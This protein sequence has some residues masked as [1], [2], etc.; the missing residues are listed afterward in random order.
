MPAMGAGGPM[1]PG[2][3]GGMGGGGGMA[4]AMLGGS[5]KPKTLK[6]RRKKIGSLVVALAVKAFHAS[7][8]K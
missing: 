7:M 4:A 1:P 6:L 5:S 3:G 8:R 2:M